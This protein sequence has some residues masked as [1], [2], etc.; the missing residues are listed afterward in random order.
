[1]EAKLA[2]GNHR[3][4]TAVDVS[5]PGHVLF[6]LQSTRSF[7]DGDLLINGKATRELS[8]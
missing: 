5:L 8:T 4:E 1:M 7:L 2:V 3:L 6:T